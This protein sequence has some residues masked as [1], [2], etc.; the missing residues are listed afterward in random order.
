MGSEYIGY[1]CYFKETPSYVSKSLETHNDLHVKFGV[2]T[3]LTT[4][5][6]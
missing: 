1:M 5:D 2:L 3:K 6:R 4:G